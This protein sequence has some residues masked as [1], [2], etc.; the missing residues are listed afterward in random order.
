MRL[1]LEVVMRV[2]V[3]DQLNG[4]L[5]QGDVEAFKTLEKALTVYL[6]AMQCS[7]L[8][9]VNAGPHNVEWPEESQ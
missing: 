5:E 4:L 7:D 9:I 2:E 8:K 1:E 3:P 6:L